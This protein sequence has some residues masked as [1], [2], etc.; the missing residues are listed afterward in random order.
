MQLLDLRIAALLI[1]LR[2]AGKGRDH[3]FLGLFFPLGNLVGVN[4]V[5]RGELGKGVFAG[6]SV[7]RDSGL[8]LSSKSSSLL[9][10][11]GPPRAL[12]TST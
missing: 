7:Q 10:H 3:A 4:A 9:G 5:L 8:E 2:L 6:Q 1:S 12:F 11:E